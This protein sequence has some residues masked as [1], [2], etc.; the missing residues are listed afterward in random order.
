MVRPIRFLF[1]FF[2][3]VIVALPG[4]SQDGPAPLRIGFLSVP[5]FCAAQHSR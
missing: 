2:L 4:W 3:L 5:P 1:S